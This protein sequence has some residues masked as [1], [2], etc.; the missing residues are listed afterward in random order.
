MV[1]FQKQISQPGVDLISWSL[2]STKNQLDVNQNFL[3]LFH[4]LIYLDLVEISKIWPNITL[5]KL[6]KIKH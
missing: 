2:L 4:E 3:N 1:D 5:L 6:S